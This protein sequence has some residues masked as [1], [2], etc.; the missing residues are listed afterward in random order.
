MLIIGHRGAKGLVKENTIRSFKKAEELGVDWLETDLRLYKGQIILSHGRAREQRPTLDEL[1]AATKL[2][3]HLELKEAGFEKELLNK[4]KYF[5]SEVVIS[6][7]RINVLKKIRALDEKVKLALI[8]SKANFLLLA[9][10]R[11]LNKELNF[12]S[13]HLDA[14]ITKSKVVKLIKSLNKKIFVW[15]VNNPKKFEKLKSLKID[16]VF[17]DFPNIIKK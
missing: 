6:S 9:R 12:Y 13:I 8:L 11:K 10:L 1:L 3:L 14:F 5:P 16:G 2:P 7:K 15:T 4:I 17:T